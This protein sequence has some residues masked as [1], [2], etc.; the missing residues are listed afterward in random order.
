MPWKTPAANLALLAYALAVGAGA[1]G[2]W[3]GARW[4]WR[5]AIATC[6]L[7]LAAAVVAV[8][9]LVA[10][11]AYLR[12]VYGAFGAGASIASLLLAG[13]VFQLLGLYPAVRL[14]A[15]LR[16]EVREVVRA[17]SGRGPGR[18]GAGGAAP[19]GG[20]RG[21]RAA[22]RSTRWPPLPDGSAGPC[23]GG[24]AGAGRGAAPPRPRRPWPG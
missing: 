6:L 2:L 17:G 11:W 19:A 3:R 23:A 10:S 13:M 14:R 12:A 1:P 9:G 7:G 24:R 15:L 4:A 5:L 8:S 16:R 22:M 20:G 18:P 21:S